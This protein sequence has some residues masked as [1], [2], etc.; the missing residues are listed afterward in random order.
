MKRSI[1]GTHHH[2]SEQHLHRYLSEF[3]I[4]YNSRKIEDGEW[5]VLAIRKAKG[6]LLDY[7]QSQPPPDDL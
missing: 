3:D 4:R 1:D 6:K 2:I 7:G 5:T